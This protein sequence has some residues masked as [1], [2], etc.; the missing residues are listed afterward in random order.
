MKKKPVMKKKLRTRKV[1]LRLVILAAE[2]GL[3]EE[4][5]LDSVVE[6]DLEAKEIRIVNTH[7]KQ[8]LCATGW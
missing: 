6:F 5:N 4:A 1:E 3:Y 2:M 7:N 8:V